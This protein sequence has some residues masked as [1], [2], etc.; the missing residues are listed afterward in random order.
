MSDPAVEPVAPSGCLSPDEALAMCGDG[1]AARAAPAAF[2]SH[3]ERCELC[4]I[5]VAEAARA[6]VDVAATRTASLLTL[7]EGEQVAARYRIVRFIARGGMGEVYE[8]FDQVLQERV[9]LKTLIATALDDDRAIARL[10]VEVRVA[11]RVTHPNVSRLLEFG[12]HAP[13]AWKGARLP[14]LTMEL[15]AGET[16]TQRLARVGPLGP[17]EAL[18][19]T[20]QIVAGLAAIHAAGIVHR[21]LKSDNVFLARSEGG[22][23]RVVVMDFGLARAPV[24]SAVGGQ[25]TGP[26]IVGTVDYI[27]PEQLQGAAVT[28]AAD[29]YALGVVLFEALTGKR[30]F[31]GESPLAIALRRLNESPPAPSSLRSDLPRAWDAVVLGCLQREPEDRFARVEDVAA[32]LAPG[33]PPRPLT[34]PRPLRLSPRGLGLAAAAAT[35]L[36][37]AAALVASG[38]LRRADHQSAAVATRPA[39]AAPE[40]PP[41]AVPMVARP[42]W[43]GKKWPVREIPV[44]VESVRGIRDEKAAIFD[45]RAMLDFGWNARADF[46]F[47]D[48][49]SCPPRPRGMITLALAEGNHHAADLG[50]RADGPVRVWIGMDLAGLYD[51]VVHAFGRALGF[52]LRGDRS[53]SSEELNLVRTVYGYKPSGS[54]VGAWGRCLAHAADGGGRAG[55]DRCTGGP[56]RTWRRHQGSRELRG[57]GAEPRCASLGK[58]ASKGAKKQPLLVSGCDQ[59]PR[60]VI[61]FRGVTWRAVGDL[62]VTALAARKGAEMGVSWCGDKPPHRWDFFEGDGRIRLSGTDLCVTAP[63]DAVELGAGL[64]LTLEPC[65]R[66]RGRQQFH[67]QPGGTIKLDPNIDLCLAMGMS[68][69]ELVGSLIL[70]TW[71]DRVPAFPHNTFNVAGALRAG[72]GCLTVPATA[73]DHTPVWVMPCV[74]GWRNQFWEYHW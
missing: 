37:V 6:I 26:L 15:L 23:E 5:L 28:P 49:G 9:A 53:L 11:R 8:A 36:V 46:W 16:L 13:A 7:N 22:L 55:L 30:P 10:A 21:D 14:F 24:G 32:A 59:G 4:R 34:R 18:G 2:Q 40:G 57:G 74:G 54:L 61:S 58:V 64:R 45:V 38:R 72:A 66:G 63:P 19:L 69:K 31:P 67:F 39:P 68:N 44:C 29:I 1:T 65:R 42:Q 70:D 60:D 27:A 12:F 43:L 56:D 41:P 17:G 47:H 48:A 50:Y 71:C 52:G 3:I 20:R 51:R 35:L 62:C 33:S 73:E 25:G